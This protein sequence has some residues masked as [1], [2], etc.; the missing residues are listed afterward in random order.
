MHD[1]AIRI[2]QETVRKEAQPDL[3]YPF[4]GSRTLLAFAYSRAGSWDAAREWHLASLQ[5][6][7]NTDHIYTTCFQSLSECGLGEI[8]LRRHDETAA[9]TWFRRA[10]YT[11]SESRRTAGGVRLLIRINT[12]LACAYAVTGDPTRAAELADEAAAQIEGLTGQTSTAT[13]ECSFAQLWVSLACARVRLADREKAAEYLRR[14]C[15]AGW[16][17]ANWLRTDPELQPLRAYPLFIALLD[18]LGAAATPAIPPLPYT[19]GA[20]PDSGSGTA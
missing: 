5:A 15:E 19:L 14:A 1:D 8:E 12:G 10:R 2:L 7:R 20:A 16:R 17:D 11:V 13:F 18:E 4:V 9:L 3:I 6:L